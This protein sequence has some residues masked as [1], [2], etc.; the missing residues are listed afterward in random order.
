M[1]GLTYKL[2]LAP[3]LVLG[4]ALAMGLKG[5]VV[6]ISV[7]EAAMAPMITSAVVAQEFGAAPRLATAMVGMG[8]PL[9]LLTTALWY[10]GLGWLGWH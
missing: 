10:W 6:T 2:V 1:A 8:I 9:S 5:Q 7:F 4:A 3:L